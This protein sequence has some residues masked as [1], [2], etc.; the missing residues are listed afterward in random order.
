MAKQGSMLPD[1]DTTFQDCTTLIDQIIKVVLQ[2]TDKLSTGNLQSL[3]EHDLI[4]E[5]K[6]AKNIIAELLKR[7]NQSTAVIPNFGAIEPDKLIG[8]LSTDNFAS[9]HSM[10]APKVSQNSNNRNSPNRG[11][12]AH[13]VLEGPVVMMV[14]D[15][16]KNQGNSSVIDYCI[17]VQIQNLNQ[18]FD[19]NRLGHKGSIYVVLLQRIPDTHEVVLSASNTYGDG[20]CKGIGMALSVVNPVAVI[21]WPIPQIEK[22]ATFRYCECAALFKCCS[23]KFHF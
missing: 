2:S 12:H 17:S 16:S 15:K 23:L 13:L 14:R 8:I 10:M 19:V 21:Q 1:N 22:S 4:P 9:F 20:Q 18:L 7:E 6:D 5:M 11:G 3:L